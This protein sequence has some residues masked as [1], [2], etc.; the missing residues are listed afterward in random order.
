MTVASGARTR[1]PSKGNASAFDNYCEYVFGKATRFNSISLG[2]AAVGVSADAHLRNDPT[3]FRM[4]ETA[5]WLEMNSPICDAVVTRLVDNVMRDV[6]ALN[7]NSGDEGLDADLKAR[8]LDWGNDP[9]QCDYQQRFTLA[10]ASKIAFRRVV[11]DGDV[12]PIMTDE[13]SLQ[14][15]EAH[16]LRTPNTT[17]RRTDPK[18]IP[19]HGVER[20]SKNRVARYYFTKADI[21]TN[22]VVQTISET[23]PRDAWDR[24]GNPQVLHLALPERMSGTRGITGFKNLGDLPG[25]LDD[26]VLAKIIAEHGRACVTFFRERDITFDTTDTTADDGLQEITVDLNEFSETQVEMKPGMELRGKKGEK[27]RMESPNIQGLEFREFVRFIVQVL[28]LNFGVP[29]QLLLL[30]ASET[31]FSGWRGAIGEA[32]RKFDALL[33]EMIRQFFDPVYR[34]WLRRTMA[35]SSDLR[36]RADLAA[37][38]R[39]SWDLPKWLS[40]QPVDDATAATMRLTTCQETLTAFHQSMGGD[41]DDQFKTTVDERVKAILYAKQKAQEINA[42]FPDDADQVS[43]LTLLPLP[44]S[45]RVKISIQAQSGEATVAKPKGVTNAA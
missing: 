10:R 25:Q 29:L 24:D 43:W 14:W 32:R 23:A 7:P 20:D 27:L 30:D 15:M 45:D 3:Y 26:F 37:K 8:W 13:G 6:P 17:L 11:V 1:R 5:R 31:N 36:N 18:S 21:G 39:P 42:A 44:L 40:I 22:G 38:W 9:K 19:L 28:S 4:M 33:T 34:W 35:M 12:L 2:A 41:W 16:R